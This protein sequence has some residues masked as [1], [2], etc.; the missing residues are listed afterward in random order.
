MK[1]ENKINNN[2]DLKHYTEVKAPT[3]KVKINKSI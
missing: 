1:I 2:K 3:K